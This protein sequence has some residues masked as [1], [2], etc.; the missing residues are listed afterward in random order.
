M[1][2]FST[3]KV[4]GERCFDLLFRLMSGGWYSHSSCC[5]PPPQTFKLTPT[6]SIPV[7]VD[8]YQTNFVDVADNRLPHL[9]PSPLF[10]PPIRT[11]TLGE[12]ETARRQRAHR[13]PFVLMRNGLGT[14]QMKK[15]FSII[16][17]SYSHKHKSRSIIF[18]FFWISA[19]STR[20]FS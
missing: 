10:S 15:P 17:I 20:K 4:R 1:I 7:S 8:P 13:D 16:L 11:I 18:S 12:E 3:L 6:F 9:P 14:V 5:I 2:F 19:C